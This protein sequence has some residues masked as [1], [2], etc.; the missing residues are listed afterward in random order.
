MRLARLAAAREAEEVEGP[1]GVARESEVRQNFAQDGGE[2][3]TVAREA[4]READGGMQRMPIDEEVFVGSHGVVTRLMRAGGE[5]Y[6]GKA[7]GDKIR[8]VRGDL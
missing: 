3:E 1:R 7:S 6:A 4:G 5:T 2:F 8:D